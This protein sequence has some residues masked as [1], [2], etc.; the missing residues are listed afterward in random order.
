MKKLTLALLLTAAILQAQTLR[1]LRFSEKNL[2][3]IEHITTDKGEDLPTTLPLFSIEINR[4]PTRTT[5]AHFLQNIQNQQL[6]VRFEQDTAFTDGIRGS[7]FFKNISSE[8]ILLNNIVP[9]GT[10]KDAVFISGKSADGNPA[11]DF[12]R[13]DS[14]VGFN[15][16]GSTVVVAVR[17]IVENQFLSSK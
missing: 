15:R 16:L 3:E 17:G 9:F 11:H 7:L 14:I 1:Q 12:N 5:D 4:Q 8:E 13:G 2:L 10:L 6:K